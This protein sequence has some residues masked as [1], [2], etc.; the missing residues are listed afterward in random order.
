MFGYRFLKEG[1]SF[2]RGQSII[3]LIVAMAV[4]TLMGAA[5]VSLTLGSFVSL[6]QSVEQIQAESLAQEGMEGVRSVRDNNWDNLTCQQC[7]LGINGGRWTLSEGLSE[8]IGQFKRTIILSDVYRDSNNNIVESSAPGAMIDRYSREVKVSVSWSI[9]A[10]IENIIKQISYLTNWLDTTEL[11]CN[12]ANISSQSS[13]DLSGNQDA[14]KIAHKGDYAYLV[15]GG[16]NPNFLAVDVSDISLPFIV[17]SLNL[18]GR[19]LNIFLSGDYAYIASSDN[20]QELQVIDISSPSSLNLIGS[21]NAFGNRDANGIYLSGNMAYLVTESSFFRE[22]LYIIDVSS[23]SAPNLFGA[24]NLIG[25]ANEIVV[26]GDY[27]YIAS[28]VNSQEL[29][30][31]DVSLPA[32]PNLV[33]SYNLPGGANALTIVGQGSYVIIGQDNGQISLFDISTPDM[34]ILLSDFSAGS[35]VNDLALDKDIKYLFAANSASQTQLQVLDISVPTSLALIGSYDV[36]GALYG[37]AG[38]RESCAVFSASS[39]NE[40]EFIVLAPGDP[41]AP[42]CQGTSLSCDNFDQQGACQDQNGCAWQTSNC[43]GSC[44][45]CRGLTLNQ[46]QSQDGCFWFLFWCF[47]ACTDCSDISDQNSCEIQLGCLWSDT[48]CG[49]SATPCSNYTDE[50]DCLSQQ[51]CQWTIP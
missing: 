22:E 43:S 30:V 23:P 21:Y 6:E 46:C 37:T 36:G 49:G 40:A 38:S 34:P 45:S 16:D 11:I 5:I 47:G 50:A 3:E 12:W 51:G 32:S 25:A 19:A 35:S 4:F 24:L 41:E 28:D 9:R 29:Q 8:M 14:L 27:A 18:P 26:L 7:I 39:V 1:N 2:S 48:Y 33:G 17:D 42:F 13:L 44:V 31:V 20:N 10:G 15:R